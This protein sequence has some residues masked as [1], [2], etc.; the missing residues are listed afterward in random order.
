MNQQ[1][2]IHSFERHQFTQLMQQD[3]LIW[4]PFF[5]K[6]TC[7]EVL[8]EELL[9]SKPN[10]NRDRPKTAWYSDRKTEDHVISMA[11]RMGLQVEEFVT[12]ADALIEERN[13]T[14]HFSFG[15]RGRRVSDCLYLFRRFPQLKSQLPH[16][17]NIIELFG[18][19]GETTPR[20]TKFPAVTEVGQRL[21]KGECLASVRPTVIKFWVVS[22]RTPSLASI[23]IL[24]SQPSGIKSSYGCTHYE[25]LSPNVSVQN[26]F[27]A[28]NW[29]HPKYNKAAGL[30]LVRWR[31]LF[32][33][34]PIELVP[35]F[36]LG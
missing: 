3:A 12:L 18:G 22:S 21:E 20:K 13:L 31:S 27:P 2:V 19:P 1:A 4:A 6:I 5:I 25:F 34:W 15:E 17:A 36:C 8:M 23:R 33:L 28:L 14:A 26:K 9:A 11:A 16:Q 24:F 32:R 7:G 30:I 29:L 35:P 10:K